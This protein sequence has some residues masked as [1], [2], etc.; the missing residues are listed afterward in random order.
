MIR[1][2]TPLL[3]LAAA[4]SASSFELETRA[5]STVVF[6]PASLV[7]EDAKMGA[8]I[9]ISL[10]TAPA[11]G[12]VATVYFE[13]PGLQLGA[14]TLQFTQ[15]NFNVPQ[16]LRVIAGGGNDTS[17][18]LTAQVYAP[19][20]TFHLCK[21]TAKVTRK[22]YPSAVCQSTGDPHFKTFDGKSY[23]YQA[24]GVQYLVKSPTFVLQTDQQPC[25]TGVTCNRAFAI[26]FGSSAIKL[27]AIKNSYNTMEVTSLTPSITGITAT[28]NAA[29]NQY[30]ISLSDGTSITTTITPW[31][32]VYYMD[33]SIVASG[34][35]FNKTDGLC[36]NFNQNANDDA[37][38]PELFAVPAADNILATGKPL[39]IT[40]PV[41]PNSEVCT[42]PDLANIPAQ[43]VYNL[44]DFA[45]GVDTTEADSTGFKKINMKSRYVDPKTSSQNYKDNRQ[46]YDF[47]R[48]QSEGREDRETVV[49]RKRAVTQWKAEKLCGKI[50]K[51]DKWCSENVDVE[52]YVQS[53]IEDYK[54]TGDRSFGLQARR[55]F[56]AACGGRAARRARF[57]KNKKDRK[58]MFGQSGDL[59][60][61][62]EKETQPDP[63]DTEE[64]GYM[65]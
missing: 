62:R 44:G 29:K 24:I 42:I 3:L 45:N 1:F 54:L 17:F 61:K 20:S 30:Q 2:L 8:D 51:L 32:G 41:P 27:T 35:Q 40:L 65:F 33:A 16:P 34:S 49:R 36:G 56:L 25:N 23:N 31:N 14:C 19:K 50:R 26:Q 15:T 22:A 48:R 21:D 64:M 38:K 11:R 18:T 59:H 4:V 13:A 53:C 37:L 28:A 60:R 55:S 47:R 63:E 10:K 6:N 12:E 46:E 58:Q 43:F 9:Q 39:S 5:D 57:L 52:Y 7:I